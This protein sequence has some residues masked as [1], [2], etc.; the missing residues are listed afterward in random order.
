[1]RLLKLSAR[2]FRLLRDLTMPFSADVTVL[3]GPNGS[4][5]SNVVE[6]LDVL[7]QTVQT[8]NY[9]ANHLSRGFDRVVWRHDRTLAI[10]FSLLFDS[11]PEIE[12]ELDISIDR[13]ER[14]LIRHGDAS[15]V[16]EYLP[17][18]GSLQWPSD[19]SYSGSGHPLSASV[20][21]VDA[22]REW[23]R[24]RVRVDPFRSVAHEY[25][26]SPA[27]LA[28]P[29]GHDLVRVLHYHYT[30]NRERFD[31]YEDRVTRV[32]PEI[33]IIEAPL[34][35]GTNATISVR[36]HGDDRRYDLWQL[37]SGVKDVLILLAAAHFSQ[38]GAF[39]ILE[40]PENHLHPGAQRSLG[41]V[42]LELAAT[43][44]KQ[45]LVTTHSETILGFFGLERAVLMSK[46]DNQSR[47][48]ALT[49]VELSAAWEALGIEPGKLLQA[50]GRNRHVVAIVEGRS[51]MLA[52]PPLLERL[53]IADKVVIARSEGG[54]AKDIA[55]GARLLSE[56]LKRFRLPTE[57]FVVLDSDG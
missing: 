20:P 35:S 24:C 16:G 52:L 42:L 37:S 2:N 23:F 4:G 57:V 15:I 47:A 55:E 40:E 38:T 21:G 9:L 6:C 45:F 14:E 18:I 48:S 51:D 53:D 41:A 43:E 54:G 33:D 36:F 22:L 26:V 50:I 46:L 32:L 7:M 27:P 5:K 3:I 30:S 13:I 34:T 31:L 25:Q 44:D 56:A 11:S 49:D 10:G 12:Y 1:M 8:G 17:A 28:S 19:V 29:T 39:V